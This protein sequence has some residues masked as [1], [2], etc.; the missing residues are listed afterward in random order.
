MTQ[1]KAIISVDQW[2]DMLNETIRHTSDAWKRVVVMHQTEST[3]DA[4]KR[5]NA[6]V[7]DVIAA[8][9][10]TRGRGRLGREWCDTGEDGVAVTFVLPRS[11][12]ERLAI[13][14]AVATAHAIGAT[15]KGT[16]GWQR[17]KVRVGIK[18]PN[19]IIVDS[20]KIAG[21]LIEQTDDRA[22]VGIGVNVRQISWVPELRGRAI[23][24]AELGF[25]VDRL[26]VMDMLMQSLCYTMRDRD[27][28]RLIE[29]F[30]EMDMLTGK[31][32]AFRIGEREI[33]GKVLRVDPMKGLAVLTENEGEVWLPAATTSV[34]KE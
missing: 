15:M 24:L 2:Q 29:L 25:D 5:T 31:S 18:W 28:E 33:R 21:V 22:F 4:A 19:D 20:R 34:I 13:A 9:R 14:S 32:A 30:G 11:R 8:W 1:A 12:P 10:Q 27:D 6:Q 26:V 17:R 16:N 23:S 7:G 3:Q